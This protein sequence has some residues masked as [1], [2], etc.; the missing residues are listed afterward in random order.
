MDSFKRQVIA[1]YLQNIAA[2]E[3]LTKIQDDLATLQKHHA[4]RRQLRRA[5]VAAEIVGIK[6]GNAA[7][8]SAP[9]ELLAEVGLRL[10]QASPYRP[11][12]VAA[13]S[14]GYLHYGPPAAYYGKGGYE[15]TECLLAPEWRQRYEQKANQILRRL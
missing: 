8:I 2:M 1:K 11:T 7:L 15:V 4:L 13:F 9:I 12:L 3:Q 10:K 6:I 14:N 5:T